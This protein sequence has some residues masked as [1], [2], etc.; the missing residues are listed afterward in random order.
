MQYTKQQLVFIPTSGASSVFQLNRGISLFTKRSFNK[1][2]RFFYFPKINKIS[3]EFRKFIEKEKPEKYILHAHSLFI[4][5]KIALI[6]KQETGAKYIVAVRSTDVD[7]FFKFVL[8]LRSTGAEILDN[9]EKIIFISPH[10][11][12]QTL[13]YIKCRS[14]A[15]SIEQ[16]SIVIPNG[17]DD[18]WF[19][20]IVE[21]P[22]NR[23]AYSVIY[24]GSLIWRKNLH[25]LIIAC[26][27]LRKRGLPVSLTVV[28]DA[29]GLYASILKSLISYLSW[30]DYFG[31]VNDREK[32]KELYRKS[33]TFVLPSVR[34]T[35]GLVYVE[36]LTQGLNLV[37]SKGEGVDGLFD[38]A[39]RVLSV[40]PKVKCI[41][42]GIVYFLNSNR[43]SGSL[44]LEKFQWAGVAR[45]YRKV[46]SEIII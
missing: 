33:S 13:K 8:P 34:E 18:F 40:M 30:V 17:V 20:K 28:G 42:D 41:S 15:R 11:Q 12:T 35:F 27:F 43:G 9:A 31:Q 21:L 2:D 29:Q 6:H 23:D 19:S 36:A 44:N 4:N 16:K 14:L 39:D 22:K 10:L 3:V 32:L 45:K 37:I 25:K 38:E 46:Y 24:V 26:I 5:G 1:F 7:I